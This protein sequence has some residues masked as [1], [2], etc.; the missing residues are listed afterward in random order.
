MHLNIERTIF[1]LKRDGEKY[2]MLILFHT[3]HCSSKKY[4][5]FYYT[6]FLSIVDKGFFWQF[7]M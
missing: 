2:T 1:F 4:H 6:K 5:F 3:S 7:V